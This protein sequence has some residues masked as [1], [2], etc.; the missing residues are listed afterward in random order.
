MALSLDRL[1]IDR[2]RLARRFDQVLILGFYRILRFFLRLLPSPLLLAATS[3]LG[4]FV[5]LFCGRELSF[6]L[7]QLQFAFAAERAAGRSRDIQRIARDVFAHVGEYLGELLI[8]DRLLGPMGA[9]PRENQFANFEVRGFEELHSLTRNNKPIIMLGS[10]LGPF[11]LLA[12]YFARNGI[13]M[14]VF[15]R[16]PNYPAVAQLARE[17]H[18][19]AGLT[20]I[21]REE[22]GSAPKILRVLKSGGS[23]GALI[24]QDTNLESRYSEFF[25]LNAA[26]PILPI[27]LALKYELP[28]INAQIVRV[29]R[30]QYRAVV[31]RIPYEEF[32]ARYDAEEKE[33]HAAA[34]V[35]T[36]SV[37]HEAPEAD[38]V[39][40]THEPSDEERKAAVEAEAARAAAALEESKRRAEQRLEAAFA[41]VLK[42]YNSLV[43]ELIREYPSQWFW[44]HRRWRRRP[45]IDYE[46]TPQAL[47]GSTEYLVWLSEQ[48]ERAA[49]GE[50]LRDN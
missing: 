21:W 50:P 11:E 38:A 12:G 46:K 19:E 6:S 40:V 28:L 49:S 42:E 27:R 20:A 16:T 30:L 2:E 36:T 34:A 9:P 23:I 7:T 47:R 18:E 43:E 39:S 15:G 8:M 32:F 25:G 37:D 48:A 4:R 31:R 26:Y 29:N 17:I 33:Q 13:D 45:G 41:F 44:W 22:A 3:G 24:D 14:S 35:E 5:G 10:H 1:A